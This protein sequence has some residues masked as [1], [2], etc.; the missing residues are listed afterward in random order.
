M[1]DLAQRYS[2]GMTVH[3]ASTPIGYIAGVHAIAATENFLA[4]EWR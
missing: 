2:I 1:G 3:C 4:Y